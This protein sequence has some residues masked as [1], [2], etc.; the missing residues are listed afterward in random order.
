MH[1]PEFRLPHLAVRG[2]ASSESSSSSAAASTASTSLD[3]DRDHDRSA[4]S[5]SRNGSSHH[6]RRR[7]LS[8]APTEVKPAR[9]LPTGFFGATRAW[10]EAGTKDAERSEL[11]I[12][13]WVPLLSFQKA[14]IRAQ[15]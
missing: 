11:R 14:E 1:L 12:L 7:R 6:A 9:P 3:L 4:G 13:R 15:S 8:P 5:S 10:L 2:S